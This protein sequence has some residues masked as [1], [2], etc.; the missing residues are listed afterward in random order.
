[1]TQHLSDIPSPCTGVCELDPENGLCLGCL[2]N[3]T[4]IKCWRTMS[5]PEKFALLGVLRDRR[6]QMRGRAKQGRRRDGA[7]AESGKTGDS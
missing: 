4:E 5:D 6:R 7:Q 3:K 1:M 2:R